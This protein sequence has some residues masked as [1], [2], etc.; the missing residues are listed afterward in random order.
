MMELKE[1][2]EKLKK[3]GIETTEKELLKRATERAMKSLLNNVENGG[4]IS[5]SSDLEDL[6]KLEA[7]KKVGL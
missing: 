4:L 3:Y 2:I 6:E 7:I 1:I 5:I